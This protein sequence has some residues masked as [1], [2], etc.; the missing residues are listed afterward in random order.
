MNDIAVHATPAWR[1]KA[2]FLIK[3]DLSRCGM[4]GRSEQ[5]WAR[6]IDSNRFEVC[7]IPFFTYGIALGDTVQ[8]DEDYLI[9]KVIHTVGH[10]TLRVA[11]SNPNR[12]D[13][14]HQAILEHL[15][16]IGSVYE[17]YSC[18]YV[19]VDFET[20]IQ[21]IAIVDFLAGYADSGDL[22]FEIDDKRG[23]T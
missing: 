13:Q 22:S 8:T 18:G 16:R 19:A 10:K 5:L 14:I 9:L 11:I 12:I 23:E 4:S 1:A 21:E 20:Q 6:K 7:C 17:S 15:D 2:N 3:C